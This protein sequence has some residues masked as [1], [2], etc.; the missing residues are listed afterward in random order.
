MQTPSDLFRSFSHRLFLQPVA[1]P[2]LGFISRWSMQWIFRKPKP[3]D[4]SLL[5]PQVQP[6]KIRHLRPV[7]S[8]AG[9]PVTPQTLP[10]LLLIESVMKLLKQRCHVCSV[11]L[12]FFSQ[13][14]KRIF[15]CQLYPAY[16][17]IIINIDFR[18]MPSI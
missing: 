8:Q 2:D 15:N 16:L 7:C 18:V 12:S 13:D 5:F 4:S 11:E 6:C 10:E 3:P 17:L 9:L 1:P 14:L